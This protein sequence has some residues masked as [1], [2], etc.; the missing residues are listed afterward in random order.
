MGAGAAARHRGAGVAVGPGGVVE[1]AGGAPGRGSP[2]GCPARASVGAPP[3]P[4]VRC[5][6]SRRP[7]HRA[8]VLNPDASPGAA[9]TGGGGDGTGRCGP[10]RLRRRAAALAGQP[11]RPRRST[12]PGRFRGLPADLHPLRES[13][14]PDRPHGDDHP[15]R[16]RR[17]RP[18]RL[19]AGRPRP[20]VRR[21]ARGFVPVGPDPRRPPGRGSGGATDRGASGD[22]PGYDVLLLW[23]SLG[24]APGRVLR[25]PQRRLDC[26]DRSG[27]I[28]KEHVVSA[29]GGPRPAGLRPCPGGRRRTGIARPAGTRRLRRPGTEPLLRHRGRERPARRDWRRSTWWR[30]STAGAW[31]GRVRMPPSG[32]PAVPTPGCTAPRRDDDRRPAARQRCPLVDAGGPGLV[33][34]SAPG[35]PGGDRRRGAGGRGT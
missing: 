31:S 6:R 16:W 33:V 19:P 25:H 5:D 20:A 1:N 32:V 9:G 22:G 35:P 12:Q 24:R 8:A 2:L 23:G 3:S 11:G 27:G 18:D 15:G 10:G 7:P 34:P 29:P 17:V 4:G 26:R 21:A 30:C 14:P 13:G 28:R